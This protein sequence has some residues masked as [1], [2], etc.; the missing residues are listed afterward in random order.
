MRKLILRGNIKIQNVGKDVNQ[1]ELSHSV[2]ECIKWHN[3]FWKDLA[4][5]L[6]TKYI[7]TCNLAV[8]KKTYVRM[9]IVYS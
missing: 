7:L 8:H 9:F 1:H 3:H 4:I 2:G 6:K 5:S